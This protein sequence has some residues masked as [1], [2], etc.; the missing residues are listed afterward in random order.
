MVADAQLLALCCL[1]A[2]VRLAQIRNVRGGIV[3]ET[4]HD[5][6]QAVLHNY[7]TWLQSVF[8]QN[9]ILILILALGAIYKIVVSLTKTPWKQRERANTVTGRLGVVLSWTANGIAILAL[10]LAAFVYFNGVV[11][12]ANLI[13][14]AWCVFGVAVFLIGKAILFVFTGPPMVTNEQN[15]SLE[16]AP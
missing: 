16:K 5:W 6:L 11:G 8:N 2:D 15:Q 13:A 7:G 12:D 4:W 3:M 9:K 10:A 1:E 14:G